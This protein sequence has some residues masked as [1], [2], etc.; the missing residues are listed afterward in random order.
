[1]YKHYQLH[2]GI[3]IITDQIPHFRSVSIG[4]WFRAGSAY[5]SPEENGLS[6]F[7]EHMLFKGTKTRTARQIAETMDSVGGQLNAFTAKEYTCFYCKVMDEHFELSLDLL[8]DMLLDSLF[9][10]TEMEKEKSVILEE[11]DMYDDSPEDLVHELLSEAY[12]GSHPLAMPILGNS[13]L[14]LEYSRANLLD[15]MQKFYTTDNMVIAVAGNFQEETLMP[16]I[17]K[18]FGHWRQ[19]G[20]IPLEKQAYCSEPRVLYAKKDIEQFHLSLSFPGV[21]S[22]HEDLYPMLVMNNLF[23]GGMSSRLFQKIREDKG[24]AYSVFS[25]PS[26]YLTNG[27]F[28]IY[29]GMKPEQNEEVLRLILAEMILLKEKGF[30][31]EE[32]IKARE[33]LKGNYILGNETTGSRMNSIGKA[34][35]MMGKVKTPSEI[36]KKINQIQPEQVRAVIQKTFQLNRACAAL[37]GSVD[38][39]DITWEMIKRGI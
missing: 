32:F 2:N 8:S 26:N 24:L 25:Y 33:Q 9:D 20:S 35:L 19:R 37:V 22:N 12:F 13:K 4:L 5:E 21:A 28:N 16:L 17:E 11:I 34:K 36:L 7:I 39:A 15:F 27:M 23:G 14:L 29:A 6:H 1:M 10:P 38:Q 31:D 30:T 18:R 3:R